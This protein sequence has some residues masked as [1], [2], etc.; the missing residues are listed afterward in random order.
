M[1]KSTR[2]I[3]ENTHQLLNFFAISFSSKTLRQLVKENYLFQ[4]SGK[5]LW[6]NYVDSLSILSL[7]SV[8]L[9]LS[10]FRDG[11]QEEL[12]SGFFSN[13]NFYHQVLSYMGVSTSVIDRLFG[14]FVLGQRE[15][16]CAVKITGGGGG[17]VV[18]YTP[19]GSRERIS[20]F[21]DIFN[22]NNNEDLVIDYFSEI[23]GLERRGAVLE[24]DL[25]SGIRS[26]V[27]P[28]GSVLAKL[29]HRG[30]EET[31][32]VKN[33]DLEKVIH[34]AD[35]AIDNIN[36]EIFIKG[37]R[38]TSNDLKSAKA[39]A[40]VLT[41]LFNALDQPV[42]NDKLPSS[43]YAA[44]RN[45]LQSKIISPLNIVLKKRLGRHLDIKFSGGVSKFHV[46]LRRP[47]DMN[48]VILERLV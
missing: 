11:P 14:L 22:S 26:D 34:Q 31:V 36:Q 45:E 35:L 40:E 21:L 6:L 7:D 33:G 41:L 20:E 15:F 37:Q 39:T 47:R 4:R 9:L 12:L 48:I 27:I 2:W 42:A 19:H 23:D 8:K 5:D 25:G 18:L 28:D 38:L 13:I 30:Q 44:D 16:P 3:R 32:L 1:I 17:D 24:Q 29:W 43:S 46:S 10:I